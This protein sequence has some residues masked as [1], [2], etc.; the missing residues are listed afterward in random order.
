MPLGEKD[1]VAHH[2]PKIRAIGFRIGVEIGIDGAD[3]GGFEKDR[4]L[5]LFVVLVGGDREQ[6]HQQAV[7]QAEH[8]GD[9]PDGRV[10]VRLAPDQ[11]AQERLEKQDADP[12]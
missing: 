3:G 12:G 4:F 2:F 8:R 5:D 7:E 1:V 11:Q 6:A 10:D 9:M